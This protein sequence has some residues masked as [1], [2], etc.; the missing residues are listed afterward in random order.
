MVAGETRSP[1][2]PTV[3]WTF[4]ATP[5]LDPSQ[6]SAGSNSDWTPGVFGLST[7]TEGLYT[8]DILIGATSSDFP[9][10]VTPL[11]GPPEG[12]RLPRPRGRDNL[13]GTDGTTS[14]GTPGEYHL[15][16]KFTSQLTSPCLTDK[17]E[18]VKRPTFMKD[19]A[20]IKVK[21]RSID[22]RVSGTG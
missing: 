6:T 9:L 7:G 5:I 10:F 20:L 15:F 18:S 11:L 1:L 22:E 21:T 16:Q 14:V 12:P 4:V 13:R 19:T 17:E 3:P 8:K 2:S